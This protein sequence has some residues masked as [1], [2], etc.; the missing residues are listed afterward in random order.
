MLHSGKS[1]F[2][3]S[4]CSG[5]ELFTGRV[6]STRSTLDCSD[7]S[8]AE[9]QIQAEI[10]SEAYVTSAHCVMTTLIAREMY[11]AEVCLCDVCA[12]ISSMTHR[13]AFLLS[14]GRLGLVKSEHS[15][16]DFGSCSRLTSEKIH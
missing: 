12:Q 5:F 6:K 9:V 3:W 10:G 1:G 4:I 15:F 8:A 16:H 2:H 7:F 11:R 14:A 13:E